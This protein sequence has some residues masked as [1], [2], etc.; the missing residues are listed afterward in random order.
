MADGGSAP[1]A[2]RRRA[3]HA[4]LCAGRGAFIQRPQGVD[5]Q[6]GRAAARQAVESCLS[7]CGKHSHRPQNTAIALGN[8]EA[9]KYAKKLSIGQISRI[10]EV[11]C[12]A[13]RRLAAN[14][15]AGSVFGW[16]M[17]A[18]TEIAVLYGSS[19]VD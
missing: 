9:G 5:G 11:L 17:A 16:M 7:L 15:P 3:Q 18:I 12:G 6:A 2:V 10:I 19:C 1:G 8:T 4:V 13:R 14:T